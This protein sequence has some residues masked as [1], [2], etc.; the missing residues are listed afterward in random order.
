MKG[1]RTT[2]LAVIATLCAGA[3]GGLLAA[4]PAQGSV[5]LYTAAPS[6]SFGETGAGE[7]QFKT[8]AGIAVEEAT[9]DVYVVD[10]GHDRIER[11]GPEGKYISQF[12]IGETNYD[13]RLPIGYLAFDN[14]SDAAKGDIYVTNNE[15][16]SGPGAETEH[17]DVYNSAGQHLAAI[18]IPYSG[19]YE[20]LDGVAVDAA[21]NVWAYNEEGNAYEFSDTGSKLVEFNNG[22][23]EGEPGFAVDSKDDVYEGY[24][25][26][27]FKFSAT[28]ASLGEFAAHTPGQQ[29]TGIAANSFLAANDILVVKDDQLEEYGPFGEQFQ[30]P[31][32]IFGT[33]DLLKTGGVAVDDATGA[34]YVSEDATN[35]VDVFKPILVKEPAVEDRAPAAS[36]IT[37]TSALLSGTVNPESNETTSQFEYVTAREYEPGVPNPYMNGGTTPATVV[38]TG[39]SDQEVGPAALSGLSAGTAYDYRLVATNEGGTT[40]GANHTFTTAAPTPPLVST[41]P[42][43]EV[44]QTTVTLSGAVNPEGLATS[45]AFEVGTDTTYGGAKLFGNAGQSAS[46]ETVSIPVQFLIPATTYHYRLV[47]TNEDGT[48]Y[49]QDV[50]FT[51]SAVPT[52][53]TQPPTTPLIA[54]PTVQFPSVAGAITKAQATKKQAKAQKKAKRQQ[55][56]KRRKRSKGKTRAGTHGAPK[57]GEKGR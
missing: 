27:A 14:A 56:T 7:G 35:K 36:G 45:Y 23:Y 13:G 29:V 51:T 19:S 21:G 40:D 10:S 52:P 22:E 39:A 9:G 4:A 33:K 30:A 37:R 34:I 50:S 26:H 8:P 11:F 12:A 38:R 16:P 32:R 53:I 18:P 55:R 42:A 28:G 48:T 44:T 24:G 54:S 1:I 2:T 15:P 17:L 5:V 47:A 31:V 25:P 20:S 6:E 49:G 41:A 57:G 3:G 46:A 43:G